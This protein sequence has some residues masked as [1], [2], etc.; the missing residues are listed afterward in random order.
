MSVEKV[1]RCDGCELKFCDDYVEPLHIC[2]HCLKKC[3]GLKN[4]KH[5]ETIHNQISYFVAGFLTLFTIL[6][7]VFFIMER[8]Q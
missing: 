2:E 6:A 5:K 8:L 4:Y 3:K 1:I 7:I